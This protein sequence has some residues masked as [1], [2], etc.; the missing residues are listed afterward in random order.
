MKNVW[1]GMVIGALTGAAAGVVLD[2]GERGT[3]K[4]V[5]GGAVGAG[6]WPAKP[7]R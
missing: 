6:W 4:A 1:K 3:E 2:L 5:A 7:P